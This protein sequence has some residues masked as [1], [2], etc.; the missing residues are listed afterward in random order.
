MK[1]PLRLR[2]VLTLTVAAS[3]VVAVVIV[4]HNQNNANQPVD[5][6][7]AAFSQ[8]SAEG[9]GATVPPESPAAGAN[10]NAEGQAVSAQD[11]A[12]HEASL[13]SARSLR[14]ALERAI[15]VDLRS[16]AATDDVTGPAQSVT[17]DAGVRQPS[18]HLAFRC[19]ALAGGTDYAFVGVAEPAARKLIWC[20]DDSAIYDAE[21]EAPI[22]P[23]CTS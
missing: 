2:W 6:D 21:V 23:A 9:V 22:S 12:P 8:A 14:L 10:A 18:G 7:P 13:A 19:R 1:F 17:C 15:M 5:Q 20:K 16:L 11:Q 4:V 3:A